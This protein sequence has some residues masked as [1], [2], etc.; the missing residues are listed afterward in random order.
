MAQLKITVYN[1]RMFDEDRYFRRFAKEADVEIVP[2]AEPPSPENASLAHGSVGV[3]IITMPVTEEIVRIWHECG[4]KHISTRTIG[5]DHIDLV[6]CEKYGI[7]VSNITYRSG[8]VA[9]YT[10][11]LILMAVRRAKSILKR[12]EGRDYS[13]AGNIG[14]QLSDLTVGVVGTGRIGRHVLQNLSGFGC[15]LIA[16]TPLERDRSPLAEYMPLERLLQTA[17]VI[18]LH[19]TATAETN[20]MINAASIATMKDGVVIVNTARGS[21]IDTEALIAAMEQGKIGACALDVVEQEIGI[22]YGDYKYRQI[23]NRYMAILK[24]MPNALYTPH[25]AFYTEQTV[26]DMVEHSIANI[27]TEA[28]GGVCPFRLTVSDL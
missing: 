25:M 5:Y 14:T 18:T 20:H 21:L 17:D 12:A 10:V 28:N 1:Y 13:L 19:A 22:L 24:D 2:V 27:V 11:M 8:S 23:P 6:A 16:Y 15:R 9:D 26:S 3:S 7:T 4:V